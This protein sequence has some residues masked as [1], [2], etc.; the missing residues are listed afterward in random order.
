MNKAQEMDVLWRKIVEN[1]AAIGAE[2]KALKY[3]RGA[4]TKF[5][6]NLVKDSKKLRQE[7]EDLKGGKPYDPMSPN[8]G[9]RSTSQRILG[10]MRGKT[11]PDS[12]YKGEH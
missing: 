10:A 12:H 7:Y 2:V 5:Y 11:G 9:E 4:P 3:R 1:E 6:E 8:D